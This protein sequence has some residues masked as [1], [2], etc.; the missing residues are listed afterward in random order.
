PLCGLA[1]SA[2][3]WW[4]MAY[5]AEL[6]QMQC[7]AGARRAEAFGTPRAAAPFL[8]AARPAPW[9]VGYPGAVAPDALDGLDS[10]AGLGHRDRTEADADPP[11]GNPSNLGRVAAPW[12][13][14]PC[15]DDEA[16]SAEMDVDEGAA[17]SALTRNDPTRP[18][19]GTIRRKK[20]LDPFLRE[21]VEEFEDLPWYGR[22]EL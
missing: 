7:E 10:E 15:V 21:E 2:G 13:A 5:R 17:R 11:E 19:A 20:F 4:Y 16:N 6:F 18:A 9:R 3:A 1:A 12:A 14:P 22:H 8:A